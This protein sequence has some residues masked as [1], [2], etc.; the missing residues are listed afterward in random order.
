MV[1][2]CSYFSNI[3]LTETYRPDVDKRFEVNLELNKQGVLC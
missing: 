1:E 2:T 3:V